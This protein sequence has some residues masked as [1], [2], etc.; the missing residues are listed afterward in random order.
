VS[1]RM[2]AMAGVVVGMIGAV[3]RADAQDFA[4]PAPACDRSFANLLESGLA[5]PGPGPEL[6]AL[7]TRWHALPELVTRSVAAGMGFRSLRIA[8]GVS[9]TGDLELGWNA[10]SLGVG[11]AGPKGGV[12]TRATGR[13]RRASPWGG[14]AFS[15]LEV[16][17]GAWA[18]ATPNL[19]LWAVVP[20]AWIAGEAPP[21]ERW[22]E[23]GAVARHAGS[24]AWLAR[25]GAPGAPR[26]LR[27]EHVAGVAAPVGPA[28]LW[29]EAR[30][31]PARGTL[32][33]SAGTGGLRVAAAVASHPV[34]GETV[35]LAVGWG[36]GHEP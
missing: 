2:L 19:D 7:A 27:A 29:V 18:S 12:A 9:Q 28:T 30:D 26:G 3:L 16:G 11:V 36:G 22:L 20:Q 13:H 10:A 24:K 35:S 14:D 23:I 4:A 17:A 1:V 34:L 32:G 31:H 15:G 21:L 8:A 33:L 25:G 5:P 6:T